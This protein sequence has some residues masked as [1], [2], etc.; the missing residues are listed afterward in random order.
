MGYSTLLVKGHRPFTTRNLINLR[1]LVLVKMLKF[2]SGALSCY[3]GVIDDLW[4][5]KNHTAHCF[6]VAYDHDACHAALVRALARTPASVCM[7]C[8]VRVC[9][10]VFVFVPSL[11][12]PHENRLKAV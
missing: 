5:K 9:T 10:G 2:S 12:S 7:E 6:V 3:D 4:N 11:H 1:N 8:C